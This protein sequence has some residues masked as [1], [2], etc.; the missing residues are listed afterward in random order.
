M[1]LVVRLMGAVGVDRDGQLVDVGGPKQQAVLAVLALSAGHRVSTD[2]LVDLVWDENPPASAP[3]RPVLR[4]VIASRIGCWRG[5]GTLA[6]VTRSMSTEV[7]STCSS[8]RTRLPTCL[9]MWGSIPTTRRKVSQTC[10][11]PGSH[12]LSVCVA[13]HAW[14]SWLRRSKSFDFKPSKGLQRPRSPEPA[15]ATP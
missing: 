14:G 3:H 6:T 8:S 4:R 2:R 7:W 5:A 10:S 9:P 12:R 1:A 15:L 13:R 11:R